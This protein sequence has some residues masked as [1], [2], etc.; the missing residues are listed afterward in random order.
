MLPVTVPLAHAGGWDELLILF[1]LP[2]L[3]YVGFRLWDRRR[4]C[5]GE[6]PK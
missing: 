6:G 3:A 5:N 4:D 2:I 1:G